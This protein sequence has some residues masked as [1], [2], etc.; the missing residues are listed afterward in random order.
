LALEPTLHHTGAASSDAVASNS[1]TVRVAL[2]HRMPSMSAIGPD[3]LRADRSS[4]ATGNL[5]I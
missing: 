5:A 1:I 4:S 2:L 3:N